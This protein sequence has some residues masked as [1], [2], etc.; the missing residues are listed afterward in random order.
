MLRDNGFSVCRS[1]VPTARNSVD[2]TIEQTISRS[3][4]TTGGIIDSCNASAYQRWCVTWHTRVT[5]AEA[6]MERADMDTG[7]YDIHKSLHSSLLKGGEFV[8]YC[9]LDVFKDYK[10]FQPHNQQ[11]Q[12]S[13]LFIFWTAGIRES[14]FQLTW[15][16]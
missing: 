10:S 3:A 9:L 13:L 1:A 5:Y 12:I 11:Q 8:V 15:L 2:V 14:I 4:K 16:H 7:N 6:V